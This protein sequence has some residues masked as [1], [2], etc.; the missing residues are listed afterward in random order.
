MNAVVLA[1]KGLKINSKYKKKISNILGADIGMAHLGR[2]E[3]GKPGQWWAQLWSVT[4]R[5]F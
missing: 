4:G 2:E 3:E 1:I 5:W